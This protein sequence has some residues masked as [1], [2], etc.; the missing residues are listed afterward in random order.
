MTVIK[1]GSGELVHAVYPSG[2]TKLQRI[3]ELSKAYE[4]Y[5]LDTPEG[6]RRQFVAN[7]PLRERR[8]QKR[9]T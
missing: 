7:I 6:A 4:W 9:I 3:D 1:D 8:R 5:E 2:E